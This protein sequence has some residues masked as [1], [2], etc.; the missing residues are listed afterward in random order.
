LELH[1]RLIVSTV[2]HD[3]A[4]LKITI[5]CT[6][7]VLTEFV[8]VLEKIYKQPKSQI[9]SMIADFIVMPGVQIIHTVGFDALLKF[10]PDKMVDFGEALVAVVCKAKKGARVAT[11]DE[12]FI[13]ALQVAGLNPVRL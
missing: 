4:Q 2:F 13:Q 9:R 5:L 8:Y 10:W 6:Q 12:R 7:N 11:F 3:A 1:D